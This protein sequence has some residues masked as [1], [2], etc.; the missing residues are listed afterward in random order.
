MLENGTYTK[1]AELQDFFTKYKEDSEFTV[2]LQLYVT[3]NRH[4]KEA[5]EYIKTYNLAHPKYRA[6]IF[7]LDDI[8]NK[9]YDEALDS[10]RRLTV[11]IESINNGTVLNINNEAYKL[12]NVVDAKYVFTPVT[13]IF[14]MYEQAKQ[15]DYPIFDKNIREYLGNTGVNKNIYNTLMDNKERKNFFYYNNGITIV[16][17]EIKKNSHRSSNSRLGYRIDVV[18]PQIV[19]GCQTVNSIYEVLKNVNPA[20]LDEEFKDAFVMLK[21]L[22]INRNDAEQ[23]FLYTK[24]VK[25]NNSQNSINEKAF[26]ANTEMFF[27]MQREFES[28]GFL[29]LVK[30]SDKNKFSNEYR[31]ATAL[32]DRSAALISRFSLSNKHRAADFFIPLEKLLQVINAF[33]IGGLTAYTKKSNMLKFESTEYTTAVSFI[34]NTNSFDSLLALY[35]LYMKAGEVKNQRED[36]RTP[37]P[38]YLIDC[39]AKFECKERDATQILTQ[40]DTS[41]KII[42]LIKLYTG[43]C[44]SYTNEYFTKYGIDYNKMIKRPVEYDILAEK[45]RKYIANFNSFRMTEIARGAI[46]IALL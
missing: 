46:F 21:I 14:R 38:Y 20:K 34:K 43:V 36:S 12:A 1:S 42:K 15:A 44:A 11:T 17:D 29:L 35:L 7:Y 40:L 13:T 30:Q 18:N 41:E 10:K 37:I 33:A 31:T 5:D 9:F 28:K 16:C 19:N 22:Q 2:Y 23:E 26:V 4:C 32:L 39:F 3:N 8:K 45:K 27:R 25:Y 24:I 6:Q